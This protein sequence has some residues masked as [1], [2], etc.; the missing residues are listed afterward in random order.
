M[1]RRRRRRKNPGTLAALGFD[2]LTLTAGITGLTALAASIWGG[3]KQE[4]ILKAKVKA[5]QQAALQ[6]QR[7]MQQ[8]AMQ[9]MSAEQQQ[10]VFEAT[11]SSRTQQTVLLYAIGSVAVVA[12]GYFIYKALK[13]RERK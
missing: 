1:A 11:K 7:A 9:R 4:D 12:A 2:P 8:A 3:K 6:E 5:E 13:A 10:R